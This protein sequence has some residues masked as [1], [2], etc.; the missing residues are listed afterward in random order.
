M[1]TLRFVYLWYIYL[2]QKEPEISQ[3]TTSREISTMSQTL[4]VINKGLRPV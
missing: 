3:I 4:D 1:E 2:E